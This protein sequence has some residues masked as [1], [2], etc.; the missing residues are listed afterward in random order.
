MSKY[1]VVWLVIGLVFQLELPLSEC[2]G[3]K[4]FTS[5]NLTL[6]PST[7]AATSHIIYPSFCHILKSILNVCLSVE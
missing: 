4:L 3:T 6:T 5:N 2:N 7:N 1:E